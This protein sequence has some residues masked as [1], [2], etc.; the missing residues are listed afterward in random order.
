MALARPVPAVF[1]VTVSA[2]LAQE[3]VTPVGAGGVTGV[4]VAEAVAGKEAVP[5]ASAVSRTA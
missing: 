3:A 5:D 4:Q 2:R 1:Q